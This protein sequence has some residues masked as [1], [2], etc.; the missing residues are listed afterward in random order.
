MKARLLLAGKAYAAAQKSIQE[1]HIQINNIADV[2]ENFEGYG[3]DDILEEFDGNLHEL[4][5]R[6]FAATKL[7]FES[8]ELDHS[9]RDLEKGFKPFADKLS[10]VEY[11]DEY[12]GA[13]NP[14]VDYL[15]SQL[16]L[17]APLVEVPSQTREQR[18]ILKR[19][20][21]QIP[22]YIEQQG[23][24][25]N[26]EK[27]VQDSL[28]GVLRLAFPDVIRETAAAKQTKTYHPDFGIDSIETAVE[29][30]FV[31]SKGKA[32]TAIGSLY[33]DMLGYADSDFSLFLGLVYM[34]G[35][36]LTQEQVDA[37]LKKANAPKNWKVFLVVGASEVSDHSK[38]DPRPR[39]KADMHRQV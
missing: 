7:A 18:L 12:I 33:E 6:A 38:A 13:H 24:L 11:F 8:F 23:A 4:T 25:P 36:F 15:H 19:M 35:N 28:H 17:I 22:H 14:A 2:E 32:P 37:E 39:P 31:A 26:R 5:L 34:T 27:N 3:R 21:R 29:V 30:K 9:R 20:L 10:K 1:C 16:N